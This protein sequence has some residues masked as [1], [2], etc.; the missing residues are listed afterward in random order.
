MGIMEGNSAIWKYVEE[1]AVFVLFYPYIIGAPNSTP[2]HCF[3][4]IAEIM[5]KVINLVYR[6]IK[7]MHDDEG[8]FSS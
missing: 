1:G 2:L 4:V 7:K 6:R 3:I 8:G 5:W